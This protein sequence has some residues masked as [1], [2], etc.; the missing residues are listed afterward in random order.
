MNN[1]S[2]QFKRSIEQNILMLKHLKTQTPQVCLYI[3]LPQQPDLFNI[4]PFF[5]AN[6]RTL[7]SHS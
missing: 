7:A 4:K 5:S 6:T 3:I 2:L 1:Y